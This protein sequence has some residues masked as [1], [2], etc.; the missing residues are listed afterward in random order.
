MEG[1]VSSPHL[2]KDRFQELN[3]KIHLF[4]TL[5][6]IMRM[7]YNERMAHLF[8]G[9]RHNSAFSGTLSFGQNCGLLVWPVPCAFFLSMVR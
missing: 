6:G 4:I 8:D 9:I 1:T 2:F 3:R 5:M 7:R